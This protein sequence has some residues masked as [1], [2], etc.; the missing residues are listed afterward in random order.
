MYEY[1]ACIRVHGPWVCLVTTE[2]GR[3]YW[4]PWNLE[5]WIVESHTMCVSGDQT[6][7]LCKSK[8]YF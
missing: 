3:G 2:V 4:N 6:Q 8:K 1:F 7:V 5:W